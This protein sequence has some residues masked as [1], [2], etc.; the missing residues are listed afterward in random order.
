[1]LALETIQQGALNTAPPTRHPNRAPQQG[2]RLRPATGAAAR[3]EPWACE[4]GAPQRPESGTSAPRLLLHRVGLGECNYLG[5]IKVIDVRDELVGEHVIGVELL[6][7]HLL[8]EE[9]IVIGLI[10]GADAFAPTRNA[11]MV[12][13]EP[14][15]LRACIE[16]LDLVKKSGALVKTRGLR[17][18]EDLPQD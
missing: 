18:R 12:G 2:T 8:C 11:G 17:L 5:G 4:K 7:D 14:P 1:M 15:G 13:I 6:L 16:E 10:V 9:K 3:A